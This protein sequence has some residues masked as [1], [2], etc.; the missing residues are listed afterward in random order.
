VRRPGPPSELSVVEGLF[1]DQDLSLLRN[2]RYGYPVYLPTHLAIPPQFTVT[3]PPPPP[4]GPVLA[5]GRTVAGREDIR[6]YREKH[7]ARAFSAT[8]VLPGVGQRPFSQAFYADQG[9]PLVEGID[10]IL[11]NDRL[12]DLAGDV[13][14]FDVVVPMVVFAN[15]HLPGQWLHPHNDAA[16]FR[17]VEGPR[18][19]PLWLRVAMHHS[20]L[21]ERW[22]LPQATVLWYPEPTPGGE[23]FYYSF[24][25]SGN[26][27]ELHVVAPTA[28]S[29]VA[30]DADSIFHG[31]RPVAG[32]TGDSLARNAYLV[33][34]DDEQWHLHRNDRTAVPLAT[35]RADELRFAMSYKAYCFPDRAAFDRWRDHSDDLVLDDILPSLMGLLAERGALPK[36]VLTEEELVAVLIDELIPFPSPVGLDG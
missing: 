15:I 27:E 10:R 33:P 9:E 1:D 4:D 32:S 24:S 6:R 26:S 2:I 16:E 34:G 30:F 8:G 22:R 19:L 20:G 31:V 35:Y 21:F 25:S 3:E 18:A 28:N 17:G 14:D 23:F 12:I 11:D 29:G 7:G 5:F 13:F 36:R